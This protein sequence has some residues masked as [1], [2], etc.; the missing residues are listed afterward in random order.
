MLRGTMCNFLNGANNDGSFLISQACT[1]LKANWKAT[2]LVIA[3]VGNAF[4]FTLHLNTLTG[5]GA[6][7]TASIGAARVFANF[8]ANGW[9]EWGAGAAIQRRLIIGSTAPV[10]GALN[11]TLHR[12][13]SAL[14]NVGDTVTLYPGCDGLAA[15][16]KAYDAVTNPAGK[17]NNYLN[18]GGEPFT[19]IANPSTSGQP[20]L[21]TRGA[22]K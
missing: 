15:T 5:V 18:F 14:P 11:L 1:L 22:K 10:A 19:P 12:Y 3:P 21:N 8:F 13:F 16:C 17:F 7:I 4:P 2:A 9:I 6:D 20:N